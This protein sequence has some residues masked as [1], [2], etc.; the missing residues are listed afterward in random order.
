MWQRIRTHNRSWLIS[1]AIIAVSLASAPALAANGSKASAQG[2]TSACGVS[3]SVSNAAN[4]YDHTTAKISDAAFQTPPVLGSQAC[5]KNLLNFGFG[6]GLSTL[7]VSGVLH[8]LE[9]RACNAAQN[10]KSDLINTMNRSLST[11]T[12]SQLNVNV[13]GMGNNTTTVQNQ[14]TQA[15]NSIWNALN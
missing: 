14:S 4:A 6:L 8:A 10:V 13:N 3:Q 2:S 7:S 11:V 12:N 1:L 5:L 9:Q 15:A